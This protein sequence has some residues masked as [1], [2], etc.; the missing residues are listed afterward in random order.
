MEVLEMT[1]QPIETLPRDEDG[2]APF[3]V[4]VAWHFERFGRGWWEYS[5]DEAVDCAT[6]WM[7]LPEPPK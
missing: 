3:H 2:H 7:R 5:T 1:W 6:H 4:V